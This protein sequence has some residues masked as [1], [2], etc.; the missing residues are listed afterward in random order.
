MEP[1]GGRRAITLMLVGS[2]PGLRQFAAGALEE[3]GFRVTHAVGSEHALT[4]IRDVPPQAAVLDV[5]KDASSALSLL[6]RIRAADPSLP[7]VL[8]ADEGNTDVAIF[9]IELGAADVLGK[10]A[11]VDH[12]VNRIRSIVAGAADAPREKTIS[13]LMVPASAYERVYEDE[14]V[15]RVIELL[16]RSLFQATPGKL[17]ERGHRTVLVY[18]R[19]GAFL[20]C[21]RVNDVLDLLTP[22]PGKQSSF[23]PEPGLFVARCKLFGSITAGELI[24]EQCF[25]DVSAPLMEAV[26]LMAADNLINIPVLKAG[27]LVGMLPDRNLLLEACNLVTGGGTRRNR[28]GSPEA[29]GNHP[30]RSGRAGRRRRV[31]RAAVCP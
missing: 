25:V 21:I 11:D 2:E 18:S 8:L 17:T 10:P 15:K 5:E 29:A 4:L 19:A 1:A 22:A 9:G 6:A 14:P 31:R 30:P 27:E 20:G 12:L 13:E 28:Y 7:V 23:P 3:R 24:G 16:A 26:E